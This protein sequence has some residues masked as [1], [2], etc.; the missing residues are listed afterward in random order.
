MHLFY[1]ILILLLIAFFVFKYNENPKVF[2][3][4][5]IISFFFF[6]IIGND[7]YY[8]SSSQI[9]IKSNSIINLIAKPKIISLENVVS[10]DIQK[11]NAGNTEVV[12][13][14]I[15][16][17]ILKQKKLH[18]YHS[19][20]LNL[21]NGTHQKYPTHFD[22]SKVEEVVTAINNVLQTKKS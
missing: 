8:I 3:W 7:T 1:R 11:P 6:L 10:A 13:V 4:L 19:F 5:I 18:I 17:A 14:L 12:S 22:Y 15:L 20:F 2:Y 21:K 16:A 9:K